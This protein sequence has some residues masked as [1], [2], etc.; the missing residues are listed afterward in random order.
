MLNKCHTK[1]NYL[2][3]KCYSLSGNEIDKNERESKLTEWKRMYVFEYVLDEF[4]Q[5]ILQTILNDN[6]SQ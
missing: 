1:I 2:I 6:V 5:L 4:N 3:E